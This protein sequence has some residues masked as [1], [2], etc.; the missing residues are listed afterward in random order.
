VPLRD[1]IRIGLADAE[2]DVEFRF[3]GPVA[4]APAPAPAPA[5]APVAAAAAAAAAAASAAAV[6]SAAA[7]AFSNAIGIGAPAYNAGD[8]AKCRDTYVAAVR[9]VC[10]GDGAAAAVGAGALD[11]NA[12]LALRAERAA[13]LAAVARA[14]GESPSDGAWTMRHA[15]VSVPAPV[16]PSLGSFVRRAYL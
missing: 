6:L 10:G 9:R 1:G 5:A 7:Q 8:H 14:V 16:M 15:L 4:A 2:C 11:W 13:L 3:V 12:S